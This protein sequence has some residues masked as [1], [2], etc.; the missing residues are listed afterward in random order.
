MV[1]IVQPIPFNQDTPPRMTNGKESRTYGCYR[2][3]ENAS[4]K[5]TPFETAHEAGF[6]RVVKT[7]HYEHL[8]SI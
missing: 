3:R 2:G 5:L 8:T 6:A 7:N 4:R 1:S